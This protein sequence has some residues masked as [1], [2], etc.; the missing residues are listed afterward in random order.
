MNHPADNRIPIKSLI[1]VPALITL[2]V[3]L[4]RLTGELMNWSPL[5]FN[6][7][8]GGAHSCGYHHANGYCWQVGNSLRRSTCR[9]S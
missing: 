4:F 6:R 3:T 7:T 5:L 9:P 2:A 1:F 8:A